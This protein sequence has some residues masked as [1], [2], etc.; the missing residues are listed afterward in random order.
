MGRVAPCIGANIYLDHESQALVL[1]AGGKGGP[2]LFR[3][4]H[5]EEVTYE[6]TIDNGDNG[7]SPPSR[8]GN[9]FGLYY[10]ALDLQAGEAKILVEPNGG[11]H[12]RRLHR[13]LVQ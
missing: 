5:E 10:D 8:P 9:H 2:E 11:G 1:R 7:L 3:L 12:H 13:N 4:D 6:I